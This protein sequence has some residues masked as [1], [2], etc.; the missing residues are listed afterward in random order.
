MAARM[1]SRIILPAMLLMTTVV[2]LVPAA[3]ADANCDN[4]VWYPTP[5]PG[6]H[7][8][9]TTLDW[10]K[11]NPVSPILVCAEGKAHVTLSPLG[12][13]VDWATLSGC[14]A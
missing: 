4:N 10:V 7:Q 13:T 1:M 2:A 14:L 9:C 8:V 11:G 6:W 3:S 12:A 5:P